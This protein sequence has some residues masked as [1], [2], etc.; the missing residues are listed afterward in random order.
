MATGSLAARIPISGTIGTS[1]QGTQSQ[2]GVTFSTKLIY[3]RPALLILDCCPCVFGQPLC[4]LQHF[5]SEDR[6][7]HLGRANRGALP[8]ANAL[9]FGHDRFFLFQGESLLR[10]GLDT[11]ATALALLP[12]N[13]KSDSML[14]PFSCGSSTARGQIF[15]SPPKPSL[16]WVSTR[17]SAKK[18]LCSTSSR[19]LSRMLSTAKCAKA[20]GSTS[21]RALM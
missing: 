8:V 20:Q 19:L 4:K 16:K 2:S 18:G 1:V 9:L 12:V 15:D 7:D 17:Y 21:T 6:R 10:A 5:A 14:L 13:L 3:P 11:V